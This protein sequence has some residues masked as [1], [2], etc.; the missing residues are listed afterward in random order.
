METNEVL[1]FTDEIYKMA[2]KRFGDDIL[3]TK[4]LLTNK[5]LDTF[6]GSS[7][8]NDTIHQSDLLETF[9]NEI[10]IMQ[11]VLYDKF[12]KD[13]VS[14][15]DFKEDLNSIMDELIKEITEESKPE[16]DIDALVKEFKDELS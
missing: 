9:A 16:F 11:R 8:G 15:K 1:E 6:I 3:I 14:I 12:Y 2:K 10:F 4:L 5:D 13:K 7:T